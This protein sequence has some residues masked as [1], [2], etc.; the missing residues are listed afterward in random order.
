MTPHVAH[1]GLDLC[2]SP[3]THEQTPGGLAD[4][5]MT[6][7]DEDMPFDLQLA[8]HQ[9]D[10]TSTTMSGSHNPGIP[11]QFRTGIGAINRSSNPLPRA[12]DLDPR[13]DLDLASAKVMTDAQLDREFE[14]HL[15]EFRA[16]E[17]LAEQKAQEQMQVRGDIT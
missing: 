17:Q 1:H 3:I 10:P 14:K 15:Q 2:V 5:T 6:Q 8:I 12:S 11:R 9:G 7:G 16:L 4:V 13:G